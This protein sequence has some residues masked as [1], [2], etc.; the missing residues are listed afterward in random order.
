MVSSYVLEISNPTSPTAAKADIVP[1]AALSGLTP[2][3][4]YMPD[5]GSKI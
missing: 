5:S 4:P 1:I 2:P 3:I